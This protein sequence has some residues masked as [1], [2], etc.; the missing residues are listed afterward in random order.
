[1]I[2]LARDEADAIAPDVLEKIRL[3]VRPKLTT[4]E[5]TR[6]MRRY[7]TTFI[8]AA[9]W[10]DAMRKFDFVVGPRFHGVMLAVQ[11]GVP[12]GVIAHDSRT[13]EL[14]ETMGI[15]VRHYS[16]LKQSFSIQDLKSMFPFDGAAYDQRR[17]ALSQTMAE[18]FSHAGI[19]GNWRQFRI[20]E[21]N[22]AAAA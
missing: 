17:A 20:I 13:F 16:E 5:F 10:I 9:S 12:G 8:D 15:P 7:G 1:M 11:A 6:W 4:A 18:M 14:C 22:H 2:R 21:R 3:Y 19:A